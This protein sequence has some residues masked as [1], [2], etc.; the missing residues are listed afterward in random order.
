MIR[1]NYLLLNDC[2]KTIFKRTEGSDYII[3]GLFVDD[4]KHIS[5]CDEFTKKDSKDFEITGG[6]LMKTFLGME[7]EQNGQVIK[8][9]R[10]WPGPYARRIRTYPTWFP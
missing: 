1:N 10:W 3:H 7:L 9:D 6:G 8:L 4:M 5:S 2:K